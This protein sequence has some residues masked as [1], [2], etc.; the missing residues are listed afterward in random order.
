MILFSH[1]LK[2]VLKNYCLRSLSQ[3]QLEE[4]STISD[5]KKG[6]YRL[7]KLLYPD[8]QSVRLEPRGKSVKDSDTLQSLGKFCRSPSDYILQ[9]L[10]L[11]NQESI[12]S[13]EE[14]KAFIKMESLKYLCVRIFMCEGRGPIREYTLKYLRFK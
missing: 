11:N 13:Y 6:V 1:T 4:T 5:V 9:Q 7:K 10:F 8:R 2:T 3:F 14:D 12:E